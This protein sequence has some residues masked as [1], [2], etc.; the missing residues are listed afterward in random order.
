MQRKFS[1]LLSTLTLSACLCLVTASVH[2]QDHYRT[3]QPQA[4]ASRAS[5]N[6]ASLT[7]T[8]PTRVTG[9]GIPVRSETRTGPNRQLLSSG[10]FMLTVA[11]VPTAIVR[12]ANP[13]HTS[14]NLYIPVAGPW[15]EIARQPVS[16]DNKALMI[17]SGA[18]QDLGAFF[19]VMGLF[20]PEVTVVQEKI[21]SKRV[22]A[23]PL[24]GA[25]TLGMSASG[26]F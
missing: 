21:A 25:G 2:A 16:S 4:A 7:Y 24:A 23:A 10:M 18:F 6:S 3:Y 8:Q 13:K 1:Q 26:R 12:F 14:D 9:Q 15:L 5:T 11:Y 20:V 22:Q 17:L 19:F